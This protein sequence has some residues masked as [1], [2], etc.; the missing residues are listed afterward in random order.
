MGIPILKTAHSPA[1][2]TA[3]ESMMHISV[4]DLLCCALAKCVLLLLE[5]KHGQ[6][7][8]CRTVIILRKLELRM[9]SC[10]RICLFIRFMKRFTVYHH[11][12]II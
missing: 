3:S 5:L 9:P 2:H 1:G 10:R 8:E 12:I 7:P 6:H 4:L 11:K